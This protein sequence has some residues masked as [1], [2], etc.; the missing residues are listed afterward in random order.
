MRI[1]VKVGGALVEKAAGRA[2]LARMVASAHATGHEC[3][4]VH[5]GGRQ[6]REV[7]GMLGLEERRHEGLRITDAPTARAVTWVLAGEVNKAI[8][9]AF[10]ATTTPALGMCGA[11]LALFTPTRKRV[12]G[13]ELGFVGTLRPEDVDASRLEAILQG[14]IVPV[15]ATIG[16]ERNA[17]LGSPFL[18]VNADEA[19]GPLAAALACDTLVLLSDIPGVLDE[20]GSVIA[21]IDRTRADALIASGTIR[22][23]MIP[24]IRAALAAC[25][26]G[27]GSVHIAKGDSDD[28]LQSAL[29]GSGT[30]IALG[31]TQ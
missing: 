20:D 10:G 13:A 11:D 7:T 23:G 3:I 21:S 4:L 1:C 15:L 8:V 25:E 28:A 22:G 6:I 31:G 5:G 24:K 16:P 27:V 19:A 30:R 18:N 17:E 9:T 26:D 29:T 2:R 14:G 12:D